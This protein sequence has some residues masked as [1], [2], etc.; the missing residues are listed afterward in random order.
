[1]AEKGNWRR[2]GDWETRGNGDGEKKR[3]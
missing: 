2:N 1:M 3:S